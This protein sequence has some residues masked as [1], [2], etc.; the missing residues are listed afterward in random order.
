MEN[1]N[2][3]VLSADLTHCTA[4]ATKYEDL[5][6]TLTLA[7]SAEKHAKDLAKYYRDAAEKIR[8]VYL[9]YLKFEL[10]RLERECVLEHTRLQQEAFDMDI[11][12][13]LKREKLVGEFNASLVAPTGVAAVAEKAEEKKKVEVEVE[14][15]D[16]ETFGDTFGEVEDLPLE[17]K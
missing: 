13:A 16:E 7:A 3:T 12:G 15:D 17:I 5:V 10:S 1:V 14:E 2:L 8:D 9:G 6:F 4:A 11:A